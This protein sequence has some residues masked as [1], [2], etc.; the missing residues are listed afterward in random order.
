M[1]ALI[2]LGVV[3][4]QY[5]GQQLGLTGVRS[6]TMNCFGR[7]F[8]TGQRASWHG[9][10]PDRWTHALFGSLGVF[11]VHLARVLYAAVVLWF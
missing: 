8:V 1:A 9:W 3:T 10:S 2:C 11:G 4:E 7:S 6:R 5:I